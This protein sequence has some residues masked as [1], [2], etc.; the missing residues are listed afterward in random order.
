MNTDNTKI[1]YSVSIAKGILGAIPFVGPLIAETV[2]SIIPRQRIDR[3]NDFLLILENKIEET[4]RETAKIKFQ[5]EKFIDILE[6]SMVQ[7]SR[8]LSSERKEYIASIVSNG[9]SDEEVEH[10]QKKLLLNILNELSDT[11][12]IVLQGYG[13]PPGEDREYFE[14]HKEIL[15]PP[16]VTMRTRD[17]N[18]IDDKTLYDAQRNHLVRMNLIVPKYKSLKKGETPEF[19]AATGTMKS[20]GYKVTSLGRLL[21]RNIGLKTW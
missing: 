17:Q 12:I 18:G 16:I 4:Q 11:E 9:I 1:D 14:K 20:Q 2:G 5:N 3:I 8:A 6:D 13:L 10:I 7:A 15:L 21:L 19:D